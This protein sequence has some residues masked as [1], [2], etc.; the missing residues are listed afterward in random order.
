MR[1]KKY[2]PSPTH[3]QTAADEGGTGGCGRGGAG[4]GRRGGWGG[5]AGGGFGGGEGF[6]QD[7]ERRGADTCSAAREGRGKWRG[8]VGVDGMGVVGECVGKEGC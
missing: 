1:R 7:M 2:K 6:R 4:L 3:Y 5:G 8:V